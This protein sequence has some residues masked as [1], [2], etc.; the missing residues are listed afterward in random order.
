M[1]PAD[2]Q[3]GIAAIPVH[4]RD[5]AVRITRARAE[6]PVL[7]VEML[8]RFIKVLKLQHETFAKR[9]RVKSTFHDFFRRNVSEV[10]VG[11][12]ILLDPDDVRSCRTHNDIANS[13]EVV[14]TPPCLAELLL[15]GVKGIIVGYA[16]HHEDGPAFV[17]WLGRHMQVCQINFLTENPAVEV[18]PASGIRK[19]RQYGVPIAEKSAES[20]TQTCLALQ[21]GPNLDWV[22]IERHL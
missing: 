4:V 13:V 12:N 21:V 2:V 19:L 5:E 16:R 6:R 8:F 9:E 11:F 14:R 3:L 20:A 17:L 10:G 7:Y 22:K 1:A 15:A 18:N